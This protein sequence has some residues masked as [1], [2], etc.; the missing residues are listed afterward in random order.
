MPV[1]HDNGYTPSYIFRNHHINT[2][3][4]YL[5]RERPHLD[6]Q[7]ESIETTD[8][9]FFDVDWIHSSGKDKL[10]IL[11]HGLEG[12]S[13]S[14]YI[15]GTAD[16]FQNTG[17]SVAAI[18]FRSC[19]GTINRGKKLYHSGFTEDLEHFL[20]QKSHAF[21]QIFLCGFSLGGSVLMN[22]LGK[23]HGTDTIKISAAAG[24][25]VPCDLLSGSI[26][27]K[28]WYN[29]IY[30]QKF[31]TS[32]T[33]KI[34]TL[35]TINPEKFDI[36][37]IGKIRSLMDFDD[38]YTAP[39]HG[40]A[41]GL[42]YYESCSCLPVLEN[43]AIPTLL[44]NAQDDSFLTPKAFPYHIAE[45]H[46]YL[47]LITPRYGGHVGFSQRGAGSYWNEIQVLDFFNAHTKH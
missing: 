40:F 39:I 20:S 29:Y 16:L 15:L 45:Q 47:H 17:Y 9:D 24:I 26:R 36:N 7:R 14:Q 34:I 31:L 10:V 3:Y 22:Y 46:D 21:D 8:G 28:K 5:F 30:E 18:N 42:D 38:V 35:N 6:F 1:L 43:I 44:I 33:Q 11:L 25:S 37:N 2:I 4:P 32:L 41:D 23:R 19:G 13:Q 27:L 12:S